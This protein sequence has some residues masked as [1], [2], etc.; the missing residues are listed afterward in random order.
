MSGMPI[1]KYTRGFCL[2]SCM[3]MRSLFV[4]HISERVV[5]VPGTGSPSLEASWTRL[6]FFLHLWLTS[7]VEGAK[8]SP[9]CQQE[10]FYL[11][12]ED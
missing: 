2:N 1:L 8:A 7:Q 4:I 5:T 12:L 9:E 10:P 3:L 11:L 6:D